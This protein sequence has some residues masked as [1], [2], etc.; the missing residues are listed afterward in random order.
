[1]KSKIISEITIPIK[2]HLIGKK[3]TRIK[4][5]KKIIS[6]PACY[7]PVQDLFSSIF[8]GRE[9]IAANSTAEA[10]RKLREAETDTAA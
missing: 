3:G 4:N 5:I 6:H 1:M 9:I 10:V 7:C 8:S 2:H